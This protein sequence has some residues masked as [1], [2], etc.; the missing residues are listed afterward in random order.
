MDQAVAGGGGPQQQQA[1]Q[2]SASGSSQFSRQHSACNEH[3][4]QQIDN[5]AKVLEKIA[6]LYAERLLSDITLEV[7]GKRFAAHRL[8]LCASSDVFQVMLMSNNWS[9]S[10]ETNVVLRED[11]S[12]AGV[13]AEFLKYLYTGKIEIHH[14]SVLPHLVLGDKY[15]IK[16]LVAL[17]VDYMV[18]H[19]VKGWFS[20]FFLC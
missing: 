17:C 7:E 18:A 9:E 5:S 12:C 11:P 4:Q 20:F 13:F 8:I 16:D 10:Q 2:A 3:H 14:G 1:P 15:N 19:I 6:S